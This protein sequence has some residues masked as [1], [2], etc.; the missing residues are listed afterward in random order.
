[1]MGDIM[2]YSTDVKDLVKLRLMSTPSNIRISLGSFGEFTRDELID[3]VDKRTPA[4]EA[5]VRME[6]LFIRKMSSISKRI[7]EEA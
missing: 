5:A 1:L 6:L 4:G 2:A 3:Q 7:A